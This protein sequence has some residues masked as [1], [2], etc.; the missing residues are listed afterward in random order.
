MLLERSIIPLHLFRSL[1]PDFIR[2]HLKVLIPPIRLKRLDELL[3]VSPAPIRE[4]SGD[5]LFLLR[6]LFLSKRFGCEDEKRGQ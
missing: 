2:V 5:V 1:I 4:P 3:E 6:E